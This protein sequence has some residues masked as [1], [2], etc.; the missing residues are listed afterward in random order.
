MNRVMDVLVAQRCPQCGPQPGHIKEREGYCGSC[1]W[2]NAHLEGAHHFADPRDLPAPSYS[3]E[4]E[5][6]AADEQDR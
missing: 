4:Q 2:V 3:D 6:P 1:A 5:R